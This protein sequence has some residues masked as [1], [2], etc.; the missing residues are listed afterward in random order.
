MDKI[1]LET[2]REN[3]VF[4]S[5]GYKI[6]EIIDHLNKSP[7]DAVTTDKIIKVSCAEGHIFWVKKRNLILLTTCPFNKCI[8]VLRWYH[9]RG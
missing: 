3:H 2:L 7:H 6:N 1:N 9:E 4:Y 5:L 8:Q